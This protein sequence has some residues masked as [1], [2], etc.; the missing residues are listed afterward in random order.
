MAAQWIRLPALLAL[1][2]AAT[3]PVV[4]L[5]QA[6]SRLQGWEVWVSWAQLSVMSMVFVVVMLV[7][8]L[9]RHPWVLLAIE[10]GVA[11]TVAFV[12]PIY[13]VTWRG[14]DSWSMAMTGGFAQPL[15][16]AW[17]GVVVL[18]AFHQLRGRT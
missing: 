3:P 11:A 10:A 12:P 4:A 15:A 1:L 18:R 9:E 5:D 16:A 13:W 14:I 6:L 17:L 7:G 8:R 2:W